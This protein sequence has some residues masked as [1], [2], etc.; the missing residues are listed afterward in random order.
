[1]IPRDGAVDEHHRAAMHAGAAGDTTG[2]GIPG[3]CAIRGGDVRA[4]DIDTTAVRPLVVVYRAA[5]HRHGTRV[6]V[7]PSATIVRGVIGDGAIVKRERSETVDTAAIVGT[8]V[9]VVRDHA[10]VN[11]QI[12]QVLDSYLKKKMTINLKLQISIFQLIK[13]ILL[14][15]KRGMQ[16]G[17]FH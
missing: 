12:T 6:N 7:D 2:R 16:K 4:V 1:M 10:T 9:H 13:S 3:Y 14:R 17:L 15:K 5:F 8:V 11:G